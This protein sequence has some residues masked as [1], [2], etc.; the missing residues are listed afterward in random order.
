M[1]DE[2]VEVL[3]RPY[4]PLEV[5]RTF[6]AVY[7]SPLEA[8]PIWMQGK[9]KL[10]RSRTYGRGYYYGDLIDPANG[11]VRITVRIPESLG[12]QLVDEVLYVFRGNLRTDYVD[13]S[14]RVTFTVSELVEERTSPTQERLLEILRNVQRRDV[15]R[16]LREK[17]A[18]GERPHLIFLYGKSSIVEDDVLSGLGG[19]KERY[20]IEQMFVSFTSPDEL[21]RALLDADALE[22]DAVALVRGGG[23]GME[24]LDDLALL[25]TCAQMQTPLIVAVGH[26]Q[27]GALIRQVA[28]LVFI[29]PTQLGERLRALVEEVETLKGMRERLEEQWNALRKARAEIERREREI[30]ERERKVWKMREQ[31]KPSLPV[32]V[33]LA[34]GGV[35]GGIL[36]LLLGG[37]LGMLF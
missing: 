36:G 24:S 21:A 34:I 18:R 17:L 22:A 20:E 33:W 28:D 19:A 5:I 31:L 23:A 16:L 27:Q 26:A 15:L 4:T 37:I 1:K 9:L 25:E 13:G 10:N 2:I 35:I 6:S 8:S 32:W 7:R 29:S 3:Q 30:E 12:G 14:I 11:R